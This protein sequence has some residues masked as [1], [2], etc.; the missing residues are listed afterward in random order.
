MNIDNYLKRINYKGSLDPTAETLKALHLAHMQA[1]P[2]ENLS[3]HWQEPI[4]L[5]EAALYDKIVNR[6]R[7][8]FCYE[9]NGLFAA[10]C[11]ALG[12][13]VSKLSAR[14]SNGDGT[15]S[16]EF[17]HM[18]LLI[19]TGD[20]QERWLADVG[21]GDSFREPLLF[22]SREMQAQYGCYYRLQ[23]EDDAYFMSQKKEGE[24]WEAQYRFDLRPFQF[25]DYVPRCHFHQ[26]SPDSHFQRSKICSLATENG[27]ITL[28]DNRLITTTFDGSRT[29]MELRNRAVYA[30]T[31]KSEFGIIHPTI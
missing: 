26:T 13:E 29:E 9:L 16:P 17:D 24:D 22:A 11:Q 23:Q 14:V 7:G 10:L 8:G 20:G 6:Q 21:F 30:Q 12:F 1:V 15:F 2:F 19:T 28:S 25:A 4:I 31:L 18:T 5:N 3:I 27:R